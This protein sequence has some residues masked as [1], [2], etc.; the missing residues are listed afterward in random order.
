MSSTSTSE[1][2]NNQYLIPAV[3]DIHNRTK[4]SNKEIEFLNTKNNDRRDSHIS[5]RILQELYPN[6]YANYAQ[7]G[8]VVV[9]SKQNEQF[10]LSNFSFCK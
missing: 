2:H 7:N 6:Q 4:L 1:K 10:S 9:N 5:V 3:K 8:I